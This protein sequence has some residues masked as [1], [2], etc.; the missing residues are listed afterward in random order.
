ML[1]QTL[2][3]TRFTCEFGILGSCCV[4]VCVYEY[5]PMNC[6]SLASHV[7]ASVILVARCSLVCTDGTKLPLYTKNFYLCMYLTPFT[8]V[9]ETTSTSTSFLPKKKSILYLAE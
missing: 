5:T 1:T 3:P 4:G 7:Y 9:P 2:L 6:I 8:T